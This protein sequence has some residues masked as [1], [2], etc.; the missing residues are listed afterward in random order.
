MLSLPLEVTKDGAVDVKGADKPA[1][2]YKA[3]HKSRISG[4]AGSPALIGFAAAN[5]NN[6]KLSEWENAEA[7]PAFP[8]VTVPS[9]PGWGGEDR[10]GRTLHYNGALS[11]W[12]AI[13]TWESSRAD[14]EAVNNFSPKTASPRTF[15]FGKGKYYHGGS[16]LY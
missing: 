1:G 9:A 12:H 4:R 3:E 14:D 8:F 16:H 11:Y 2:D 5:N 10:G 6:A 7:P 13:I 15:F